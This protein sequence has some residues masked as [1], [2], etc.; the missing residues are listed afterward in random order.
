MAALLSIGEFARL[1]HLSVKALRHYDDVGLLTP[2]EVDPSSGY[3]RYATAQVPIAQVIR[4]FRELDMPLDDVREV[5]RAPDVAARDAVVVRHLTRMQAQLDDAQRAV[6]SLKDLLS[7]DPG[8]AE[9]EMRDDAATRSIAVRE[10]V[11]WDDTETWLDGAFAELTA[12]LTGAPAGARGGPD[13][14]LYSAEFFERHRG[15]VVAYVPLLDEVAL[16]A[17]ARVQ[18]VEIPAARLAVT[19]HR[20]P[21]GDI[22][23]T[24]GALGT[25]VAE[26]A[27]GADGPIRE[28]YLDASTTEVCWPINQGG[29]R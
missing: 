8:D 1:T 16:P 5:L 19:V 13:S 23:R 10:V 22:D 20:G 21:F 24:Y 14:A 9:V 26:R 4:R 25:F 15:E 3:R 7:G 12:A 18:L 11:D 29:A 17:A 27:L 28:R 2:A 6:A